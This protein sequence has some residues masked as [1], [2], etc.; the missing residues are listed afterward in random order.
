VLAVLVEG[1]QLLL[2]AAEEAVARLFTTLPLLPFRGRRL[3]PQVLALIHLA[4]LQ[5]RLQVAQVLPVVLGRVDLAVV[6]LVEM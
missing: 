3:L 1:L 2:A 6:V 4:L 5:V